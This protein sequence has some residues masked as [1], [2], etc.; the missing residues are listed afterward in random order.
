MALEHPK[1]EMSDRWLKISEAPFL[2]ARLFGFVPNFGRRYKPVIPV[3]TGIQ[4]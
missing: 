2:K 1:A 3:H 4:R